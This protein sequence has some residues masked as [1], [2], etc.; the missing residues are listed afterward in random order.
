MIWRT[1][2]CWSLRSLLGSAWCC[3]RS[4]WFPCP[5][6]FGRGSSLALAE[7]HSCTAGEPVT[8]A[9]RWG[10]GAVRSSRS[11]SRAAGTGRLAT[12]GLAAVHRCSRR[13]RLTRSAIVATDVATLPTP[14]PRARARIQRAVGDQREQHPLDIRREPPGPEHPCERAVDPKAPHST[15]SS[16]TPP[17]DRETTTSNSPDAAGRG[18]RRHQRR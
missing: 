12:G 16:H 1:A 8:A 11:L 7:R 2:G 6:R 4:G 14:P 17:S 10:A 3:R 5:A 13:S 9:T 18:T 15:S